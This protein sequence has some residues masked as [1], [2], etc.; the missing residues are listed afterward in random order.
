LTE[1]FNIQRRW[2]QRDAFSTTL[3]KYGIVERDT[4]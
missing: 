4:E 1:A 3:F 2:R